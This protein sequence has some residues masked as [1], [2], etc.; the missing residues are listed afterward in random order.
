MEMALI[1]N[2]N[3]VILTKAQIQ[4][5]VDNGWTSPGNP[6]FITILQFTPTYD[7]QNGKDILVTAFALK[8][9]NDIIPNSGK[10]LDVDSA[11]AYNLPAFSMG[12]NYFDFDSLKITDTAG[13]LKDFNFIRLTP[14]ADSS[15]NDVLYFNLQVIKKT[16]PGN[17]DSVITQSL[18]LPC[19]PCQYCRPPNC[20]P[21]Q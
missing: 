10:H 1:F 8:D 3:C 9:T 4:T 14:K 18:L 13:M 15:S 7:I 2:M 17:A 16:Y 11:C 6:N 21:H 19:P 12:R 5:W 20:P